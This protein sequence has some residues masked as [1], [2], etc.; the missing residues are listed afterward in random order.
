MTAFT[1]P[2]RFKVIL[3]AMFCLLDAGC[4]S[5][6]QQSSM[7]YQPAA[8]TPAEGAVVRGVHEFHMDY[9]YKLAPDQVDGRSVNLSWWSDWAKP[10]LIDPGERVIKARCLYALG[11]S[12]TQQLVVDL[13][14]RL[15]AGH[16]YRLHNGVQGNAV[17]FWVEDTQTHR[18]A[19]K[20]VAV[21]TTP[22]SAADTAI[23]TAASV[24]LRV[25]L[26]FGTGQ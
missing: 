25:L 13:P 4:A 20:K 17:V 14:V 12:R 15:E 3:L 21:S 7:Q 22:T 16:D 10:V 11:G 24:L 26:L 5:T 23:A 8:T 9:W 19:G 1:H 2:Q 6:S 18:L